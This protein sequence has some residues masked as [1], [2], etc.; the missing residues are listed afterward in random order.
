MYQA[1]VNNKTFTID[2]EGSDNSFTVNDQT[3]NLDLVSLKDGSYHVIQDNQSYNIEVVSVD[4]EKKEVSVKVNNRIYN[5]AVK[6][7]LDLLLSKLGM[8]DMTSKKVSSIK[9][10]MPGLVVD[11]LKAKGDEVAEG[12]NLL[13]LEAMKME[14][15]IKSPINGVIK[16]IGVSPK[17]TVEKNQLLI[18]F[19]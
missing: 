2:Q 11:I 16:S 1:S 4:K 7:Q 18:S 13:I 19:E 15:I 3:I 10:P 12:E 8:A 14:N 5:V 9:A 6:D 17:D